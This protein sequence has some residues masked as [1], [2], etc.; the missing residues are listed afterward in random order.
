MGRIMSDPNEYLRNHIASGIEIG[1][2]VRVKYACE[3][4]ESGWLN[5][6][7]DCMNDC[8]GGIFEVIGDGNAFG[9]DLDV[10]K[11]FPD[12]AYASYGFPYF[13][14]DLVEKGPEQ[15]EEPIKSCPF[16]GF[17]PE[18]DNPDFCYP[19][20]RPDAAGRQ[21]WRAGCIECAGG[22]GAETLGWT[23]KEAIQRWNKRVK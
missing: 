3:T 9:F 4:D 5:S 20:T 19:T 12:S 21:V 16:C 6:W 23:E 11:A 17:Q 7:E 18:R 22:C 14:L 8:I 10:S 1:D 2:K 15:P 13:V